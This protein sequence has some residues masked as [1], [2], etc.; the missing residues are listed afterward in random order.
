MLTTKGD[1]YTK[2]HIKLAENS[3]GYH[4]RLQYMQAVMYITRNTTLWHNPVDI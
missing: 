4:M 1:K 3:M 2:L